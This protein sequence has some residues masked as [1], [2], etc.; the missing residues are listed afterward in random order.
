MATIKDKYV[1]EIDTKGATDNINR[2]QGKLGGLG[3][4]IG[5]LG[6]D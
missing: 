6:C 4:A 2:T 1:L 5:R 3:A